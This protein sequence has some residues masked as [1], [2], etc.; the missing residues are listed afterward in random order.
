M[1]KLKSSLERF[2]SD[3]WHFHAPVLA[4]DVESLID[5]SNQRRVVCLINK[6][7]KIHAALMPDGLG[8]YF[9]NLNKDVRK[10]LK[11]N[12]GD[13][14]ILELKKDESKYG[15]PLAPEFEE[16]L[17][18]DPE[19]DKFFH[20]LTPG[21]QRNLIHIVRKVKSPNIRL[22]K[23]IVIAEHVKN[24]QGQI[25]FRLLNEEMKNK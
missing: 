4:A 20:Q 3:L 24:N 14:L 5:G 12:E 18:Q 15:M 8:D 16:M 21:K 13:E 10:Q 19:F 22:R 25:D 11:L 7:V 1:V 9:I 6:K 23:T 2:N 17:E